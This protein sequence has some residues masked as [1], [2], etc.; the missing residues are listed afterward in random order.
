MVGFFGEVLAVE[1]G[2]WQVQPH[3][4]EVTGEKALPVFCRSAEGITPRIGDIV[5][6]QPARNNL[7][8]EYVSRWYEGSDAS[9]VILGVY[10]S[11]SYV[12]TGDYKFVG[13]LRVTG[14]LTVEQNLTVEGDVQVTGEATFSSVATD[15]L[16]I[17]G[18]DYEAH[19]HTGVTSGPSMTGPVA[20]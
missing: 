8:A 2:G 6:A 3:I 11:N 10:Q 14:N 15:V 12:L 17:A 1:G 9:A 19:Q 4:T 20:P 18:K 13:N 16:T 7:D 5:F